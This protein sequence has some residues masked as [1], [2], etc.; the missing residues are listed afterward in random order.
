MELQLL[1]MAICKY[2][3]EAVVEGGLAAA[4]RKQLNDSQDGTAALRGS[5]ATTR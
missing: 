3:Q 4:P 1:V 2:V 5:R